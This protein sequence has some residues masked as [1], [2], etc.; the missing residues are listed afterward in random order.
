[1]VFF[2][3]ES[4]LIWESGTQGNKGLG[5]TESQGN[6]ALRLLRDHDKV[7]M[8]DR[9]EERVHTAEPP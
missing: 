8:G 4:L 7:L 1:M 5:I 3:I 9:H 2:N 6:Q